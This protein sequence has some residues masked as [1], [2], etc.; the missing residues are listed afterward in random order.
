VS[1]TKLYYRQCWGLGVS[2]IFRSL[3]NII[4][5]DTT[6][7]EKRI[8][9]LESALRQDRVALDILYKNITLLTRSN[10]EMLSKLNDVSL[11]I[12]QLNK[13]KDHLDVND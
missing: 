13:L 4:I 7:T 11:L 8:T 12:S 1:D 5:P 3:V 10:K 9:A 6:T 2:R